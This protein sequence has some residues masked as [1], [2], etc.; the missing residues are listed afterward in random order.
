[1]R[2]RRE[3]EDSHIQNEQQVA[4]AKK[5][6]QD[7]IADLSEQVDQSNKARVRFLNFIYFRIN[8]ALMIEYH[9]KI[10]FIKK[11]SIN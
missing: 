7:L 5:K 6:Q 2:L 8:L 10:Q 9:C 11:N 1:M 4:Q 3:I